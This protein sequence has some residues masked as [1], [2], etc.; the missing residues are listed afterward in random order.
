[1]L[2]MVTVKRLVQEIRELY[3][4]EGAAILSWWGL[5]TGGRKNRGESGLSAKSKATAEVGF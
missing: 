1:M 4:V 2:N 5:E 3:V